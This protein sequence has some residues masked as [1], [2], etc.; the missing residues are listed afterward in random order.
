[1]AHQAGGLRL[2]SDWRFGVHR[3]PDVHDAHEVEEPKDKK[4][5]ADSEKRRKR[6]LRKQAASRA[7]AA[8]QNAD[9]EA[10]GPVSCVAYPRRV[11]M[12]GAEEGVGGD[13]DHE[14]P[15]YASSGVRKASA[16]LEEADNEDEDVEN[17]LD[18]PWEA[19]LDET[20]GPQ[21]PGPETP[22]CSRSSG[23]A[24]NFTHT[25]AARI[26]RLLMGS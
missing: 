14:G 4:R 19:K 21:P 8:A 1:M 16:L 9:A 10:A 17:D 15:D 13:S 3:R 25:V 22:R 18:V 20:P 24:G 23:W 6:R 26:V 2:Q 5:K 7:E 11:R 12:D